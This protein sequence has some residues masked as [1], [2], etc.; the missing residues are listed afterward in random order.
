[1]NNVDL[2]IKGLKCDNPKCGY[3]NMDP[4]L[5]PTDPKHIGTPCPKCGESL[6]TQEDF[7]AMIQLLEAV[8]IIN[9]LDLGND[10]SETETEIV[11]IEM[12]G[13]GSIKIKGETYVVN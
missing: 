2:N 9:Q 7:D 8:K 4:T 3:I 6:L 10:S 11:P 13:D 1:M 5:D 12:K